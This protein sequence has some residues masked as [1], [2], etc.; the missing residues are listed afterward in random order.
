MNLQV[1]SDRPDQPR[2]TQVLN[3]HRVNTRQGQ[4]A[5]RGFHIG[6]LMGKDERI[7]GDIAS[8]SPPMQ[9]GHDVGQVI[10]LKVRRPDP[11]VMPLQPEVNRVG[12]VL[13]GRKQAGPVSCGRQKL[14][15]TSCDWTTRLMSQPRVRFEVGCDCDLGCHECFLDGLWLF[16]AFHCKKHLRGAQ[17]VRDPGLSLR[18]PSF[19]KG[20]MRTI[21]RK[22]G[23]SFRLWPKSDLATA[24]NGHLMLNWPEADD[25]FFTLFRF[26]I[27]LK[28]KFRS[29][30]ETVYSPDVIILPDLVSPHLRLRAGWDIW[31]GYHLLS[32]DQASDEFLR[33]VH[34]ELA[35]PPRAC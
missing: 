12:P 2:Q 33:R 34:G 6:Q 18:M 25:G 13:D 32:H 10:P 8:D 23:P 28:Y 7:E 1:P 3:D 31:C 29:V 35:D 9:Q 21:K 14:R 19:G 5:Y 27:R 4:L 17:R 20:L 30:G 26:W 15:L 11:R 22:S 16:A 24:A